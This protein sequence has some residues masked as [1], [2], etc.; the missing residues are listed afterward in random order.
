M[1]RLDQLTFTRFAM[2]MLVLF[3]HGTGSLYIASINFFPFSAILRSAPT[4][5]S[6][7]YV[8]SGFVM[9]LVY[10]R[11]DEKF[12]FFGYWKARFIRIYPLY[13]ISFALVCLYYYDSLFRIKPQKIVANLFVIQ[14]W[15]PA[16][17]QSFNYASWSMTVEFFFYAIFPFLILWAARRSTRTLIWGALAL[18]TVSQLV[19]Y[20][21]WIGYMPD[22]KD[23]I[24][25]FPLFHL[26]SFVMGVVGGIWYLRVGRF[27]TPSPALVLS[28]VVASFLMVAVYIVVSTGIFPVLPHDLQ[29][30]SGLL[31]PIMILFVI[32]LAMDDSR[33][34]KVLQ[35]PYLV[36][37]GETAYAIYILH[38]PVYWLYERALEHYGVAD[39][40]RVFDITFLP[41]MIL[42]GLAAHFYVD[43]PLRKRL[44]EFLRTISIPIFLLDLLFIAVTAF[45]IFKLR[46][47][48]GREYASY[49]EMERLMFWVSFFAFPL[50]SALWGAYNPAVLMRAGFKWIQ[51]TLYSSLLG[52]VVLAGSIYLG[53]FT[54]WFENFPRSIFALVWLALFALFLLT[55]AVFRFIWSRETKAITA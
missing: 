1:K 44:K 21:L 4:A 16:Y 11:P 54:G 17:S 6:Y 50:L 33:M 29:P 39:P 45:T 20:T 12:D 38:V 18:W 10:F 32:A 31:A 40:Q 55:R 48:D 28:L 34:S 35:H 27:Q 30:M 36:N 49:R 52:V 9:A 24:V 26:N 14:A 7:L 23:F 51:P 42:L 47:G 3:Y 8:L 53:Y 22:S 46:F 5:V 37:L 2:I 41:G 19:H 25:Y 15:I 43:I 13:I